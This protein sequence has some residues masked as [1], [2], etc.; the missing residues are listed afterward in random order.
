MTHYCNFGVS[1]A[2]VLVF[3]NL[4]QSIE[5]YTNLKLSG[6]HTTDL[7]DLYFK[8]YPEDKDVLWTVSIRLCLIDT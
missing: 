5:K 6:V 2:A 1:R 7:A 4:V 3:D 8:I